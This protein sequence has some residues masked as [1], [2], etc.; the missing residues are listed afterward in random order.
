MLEKK[1]LRNVVLKLHEVS[2]V[3]DDDAA[4]HAYVQEI[5]A[6]Q[7]ASLDYVLVDGFARDHCFLAAVDRIRQG[8]LLICD[9]ANWYLPSDSRAPNSRTFQAGPRNERWA[10]GL[11]RTIDWRRL[12]AGDG[13]S[14]TLILFKP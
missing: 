4:E 2:G 3:S 13:V 9:N 14:E 1:G 5:R 6:V 10:E 8:G 11:R 12:W 7:P